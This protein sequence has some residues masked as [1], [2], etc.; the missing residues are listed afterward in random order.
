M[1]QKAQLAPVDKLI[2]AFHVKYLGIYTVFQLTV[3]LKT[4]LGFNSLMSEW[5]N[6]SLPG[7]DIFPYVQDNKLLS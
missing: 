6:S 4:G 5:C 7:C 1:K 3:P 2:H